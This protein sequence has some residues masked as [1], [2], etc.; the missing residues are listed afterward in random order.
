MSLSNALSN[1][2]SG[3]G[4][5]NR[6]IQTTSKNLANALT[7]GYAKRT[8]EVG[9]SSI[10][11]QGVGVSVRGVL[12]ETA[13]EL[14]A[15]RRTADGEA[16]ETS[17]LA[18][19][20][21]RLGASLGEA[22][23]DEGLFRRVE[24]LERTMRQLAETPASEPRQ[25]QT[26]E[27]ARDLATV[28][29]QISEEVRTVRE[30]ADA[31]IADQVDTVNRNMTEIKDLNN[32]IKR[33]QFTS[34][35]IPG[36]IDE[37]ARLI[38]EVNAIV[39][40]NVQEKPFNVVHIYTTQGQFLLQETEQTLEFTASPTI[41]QAMVYDP[42]GGGALSALTLRGIDIT[43]GSTASRP[44]Q[45]GA[46]AG[47]IQIRDQITTE[48]DAQL[49]NFAAD[50]IAR[51]ED[52]ALD[53]TLTATDPGLFT[54]AGA[55]LDLSVVEGLAGRISVNALVDPAQGGNAALLRDGLMAAAPG[56]VSSDVQIRAYLDRLTESQT[57]SGI[58]GLGGSRSVAENASGI[59]EILGIARTQAERESARDTGTRQSLAEA[60]ATEIGVD[61][62]VE[63]Q[64]LIQIEQAYA[65]N[66]QVIQTV[67]R[68][69]QDIV[70]LR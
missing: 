55:Q 9:A 50:L 40:I 43:P 29:N 7:D 18:E 62:D 14:T 25:Q 56:P 69:L 37:R 34:S 3:L 41:T 13:P 67:S 58:P 66:A 5:N 21:S 32:R 61:T 57:G 38:D 11:G 27:A 39:P 4:V 8:V 64:N 46:L 70:E 15:A 59:V 63:L 24:D 65:A 36:L 31:R 28:L 12:R 23:D 16:A 33:L 30:Q 26:I 47:N 6:Q 22:T 68:M 35:E 53:P 51:F 2:L 20:L 52:T 44:I 19:A 54:D 49:D 1:A 45:T 10:E 42:A 60:E 17:V 48:L